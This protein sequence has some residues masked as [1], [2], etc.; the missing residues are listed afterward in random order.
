MAQKTIH[1]AELD[2]VIAAGPA[3][4]NLGDPADNAAANLRPARK[5]PT[6][7]FTKPIY[8]DSNGNPA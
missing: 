6:R 7:G 2:E 5:A 4:G 3:V 1:D 8:L